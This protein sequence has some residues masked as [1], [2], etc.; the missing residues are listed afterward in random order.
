MNDHNGDLELKTT[1]RNIII[2]WTRNWKRWNDVDYVMV[3]MTINNMIETME[4]GIKFSLDFTII[5][6]RTE[7]DETL[8]AIMTG[9]RN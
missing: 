1:N 7:N 4:T 2:K 5:S 3:V 9:S 6:M 8:I